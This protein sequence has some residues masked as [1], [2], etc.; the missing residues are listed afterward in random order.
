MDGVYF[1][2]TRG[3]SCHQLLNEYMT[4]NRFLKTKQNLLPQ[5]DHYHFP[6]F[7]FL[8]LHDFYTCFGLY[9]IIY[10][11]LKILS[12]QCYSCLILSTFNTTKVTSPKD[13]SNITSSAQKYGYC[14][15]SKQLS[16]TFKPLC[17]GHDLPFQ[18]CPS[19]SSINGTK[20]VICH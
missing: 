8:L 20:T 17:L 4:L 13:C 12:L 15:K 1:S 14:L 2:K 11:I 19:F 6:H 3:H 16:W 5:H 18:P 9:S 10:N 7:F